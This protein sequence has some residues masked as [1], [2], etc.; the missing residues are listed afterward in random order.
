MT[1]FPFWARDLVLQVSFSLLVENSP[2][3]RRL[4]R[5]SET[6]ISSV[7]AISMLSFASVVAQSVFTGGLTGVVSDPDGAVVAN[8]TVEITNKRTGKLERSIKSE[9]DGSYSATLLPPGTYSL[10]V[11]AANFKQLLIGGV[12]V[13]INETSRQDLK[14]ELGNITE[15]L[16]VLAARTETLAVYPFRTSPGLSARI[17]FSRH[18]FDVGTGADSADTFNYIGVLFDLVFCMRGQS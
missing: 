8:V 12:P 14:L 2:G 1:W 16:E 4:A 11:A 13:R 15:T 3:Y 5:S 7:L 9:A 17:A 6:L 10:R 18:Q